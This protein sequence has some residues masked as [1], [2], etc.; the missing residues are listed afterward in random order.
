MPTAK[1]NSVEILK[2]E[3]STRQ[4]A[5][6]QI[7]SNNYYNDYNYHNYYKDYDDN[8]DFNNFNDTNDYRDRDIESDL[9]S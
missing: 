5:S 9:V 4:C 1:E 6:G 7:T 3:R 8:N 2:F